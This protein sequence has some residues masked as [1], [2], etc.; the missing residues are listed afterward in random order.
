MIYEVEIEVLKLHQ[1]L[2]EKVESWWDD[3]YPA[4]IFT[5]VSGDE[6]AIRV[7][8]IR[9]ILN[10]LNAIEKIGGVSE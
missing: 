5:G 10:K 7:V 6:G 9:E 2:K 4:D 8:E 3:I 1:E